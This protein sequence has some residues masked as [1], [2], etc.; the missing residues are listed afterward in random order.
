MYTPYLM[1]A[2]AVALVLALHGFGVARRS[3]PGLR[4]LVRLRQF[5]FCDLS[6]VILFGLRSRAPLLFTEVIPNVALFAGVGL[7]YL[8]I[9]EILG[10]RPRLLQRA[11]ALCGIAIPA[12]LWFT[13]VQKS[14][15]SRLETHCTL[16]VMLWGMSAV[17]LFS[18]ARGP[19]RDPARACGWLVAATAFVNAAWGVYGRLNPVNPDFLHP[20]AVH[21]A[22]SYLVMI[23]TLSISISLGWL[24]FCVQRREL[25]VVAETDSLTGLL[26]RGAFEERLQRE[27][28]RCGGDLQRVSVILIDVDYFKRVNDEHGHPTGDAIL[29]RVSTVLRAG[30]RPS[31]VL[32]RYGGEEFVVLLRDA[33]LRAAEEVAERL[34]TDIATL[35]DLPRD[36]SLT[37]SFGVAT[38]APYEGAPE[39]LSR[40][41]SALYR[42]KREGRNRVRVDFGTEVHS[43]GMEC[44]MTS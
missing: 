8:A 26:N 5:V 35:D 32:A 20:D 27:L 19:L 7:L 23:L 25:E 30:T 18:N 3:L 1:F 13:Y 38:C 15:I 6:A 33:E 14:E 12:L 29:R 36:V 16:L 31:D 28:H 21:A 22:F 4:G 34:R 37:A 40:A 24:S 39:L 17:A 41:D 42:S 9:F 11:L 43:G 2:Y 44:V 10:L